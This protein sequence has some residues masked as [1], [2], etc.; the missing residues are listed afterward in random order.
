MLFLK[1]K[2]KKNPQLLFL[3][4]KKESQNVNENSL[5]LE[6]KNIE[7]ERKRRNKDNGEINKSEG[8]CGFADESSNQ[9]KKKKKGREKIRITIQNPR[10]ENIRMCG[11]KT[12]HMLKGLILI[13]KIPHILGQEEKPMT[14]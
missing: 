8:M 9:K 6:K 7:E 11:Y 2:K 10:E 4:N 5:F 1:K 13:P 14:Q 12:T 3:Q